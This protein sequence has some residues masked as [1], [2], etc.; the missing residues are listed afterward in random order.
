MVRLTHLAEGRYDIDDVLA[1]L[2]AAKESDEP[3]RSRC[4]TSSS[5]TA[6][7][8]SSTSR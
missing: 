1:R 5:T 2:A 3:A 7:P 8:I 4:T 6:P